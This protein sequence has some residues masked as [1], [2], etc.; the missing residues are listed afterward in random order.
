MKMEKNSRR[1]I[2]SSMYSSRSEERLASSI[3]TI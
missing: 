2:K 1:L 3:F